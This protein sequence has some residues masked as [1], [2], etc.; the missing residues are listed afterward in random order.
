VCE[1]DTESKRTMPS[2]VSSWKYKTPTLHLGSKAKNAIGKEKT[3][4]EGS[5]SEWN[6]FSTYKYSNS[7]RSHD[8]YSKEEKN[9]K[10]KE[11]KLKG[12]KVFTSKTFAKIKTFGSEFRD[13]MP[14]RCEKNRDRE[15]RCDTIYNTGT[16]CATS[17]DVENWYLEEGLQDE[18]DYM[19]GHWTEE[20]EE[21]AEL[22]RKEREEQE[23]IEKMRREMCW[24]LKM[25]LRI[26]TIL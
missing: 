14:V 3:D 12:C 8:R 13:A 25:A 6:C 2:R 22:E 11:G 24:F 9:P 15:V 4:G 19:E 21:E 18:R 23:R 20:E 26:A 7:E 17:E 5:T 16:V 1:E 10:M